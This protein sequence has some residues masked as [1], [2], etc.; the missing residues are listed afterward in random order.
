MNALIQT[1]DFGQT[2]IGTAS[3]LYTFALVY[4]CLNTVDTDGFD[5]TRMQ[6]RTASDTLFRYF[7]TVEF[8]LSCAAAD[9]LQIVFFYIAH[10]FSRR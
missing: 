5:R 10:L 2:F 4:G 7:I 8:F 3:T 9:F 6:T 1:D